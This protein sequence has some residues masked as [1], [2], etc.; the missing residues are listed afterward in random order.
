MASPSE[1]ECRR[2]ARRSNSQ[3][4]NVL[5]DKYK[6][7]SGQQNGGGNHNGNHKIP[8]EY[9][10][11]GSRDNIRRIVEKEGKAARNLIAYSVPPSEETQTNNK[12]KGKHNKNNGN[13]NHNNNNGHNNN[14]NSNSNTSTNTHN[15]NFRGRTKNK[16]QSGYSSQ[17]SRESPGFNSNSN[18]N[19]NNS[20]SNSNGNSNSNSTYNNQNGNKPHQAAP[21]EKSEVAPAED[22]EKTEQRETK[23]EEYKE[24]IRKAIEQGSEGN[25]EKSVLKNLVWREIFLVLC[26]MSM[27]GIECRLYDNQRFSSADDNPS[28]PTVVYYVNITLF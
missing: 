27:H 10:R 12:R 13:N 19:N 11:G 1:A 20:N 5:S 18:S 15:S 21:D 26:M 9:V 4:S 16:R 3:G 2:P 23:S 7:H 17:K 25:N 28:F 22:E 24:R 6:N 14:N 8:P